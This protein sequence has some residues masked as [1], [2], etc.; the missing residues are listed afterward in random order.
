MPTRQSSVNKRFWSRARRLLDK[1][2][3]WKKCILEPFVG[4]DIFP[5]MAKF[6]H[7]CCDFKEGNN[8]TILFE[9][10]FHKIVDLFIY[11]QS[12]PLGT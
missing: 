3:D 12:T 4:R 5:Y 6:T 2:S 11:H 8:F 10:V 9:E 1:L 7:N